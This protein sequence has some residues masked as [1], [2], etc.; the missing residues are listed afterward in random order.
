M[1]IRTLR[2]RNF[3]CYKSLE[4]SIDSMHALVGA[5]NAGKSTVLRA[6]DFLFNPSTRKIG[7]ESFYCKDTALTIEV[8]GL[9]T[10][11]NDDERNALAAYLGPDGTFR[12]VR[13]ARMST[14]DGDSG[15]DD[16]DGDERVK[17]SAYYCKPQPAIE[18]LNPAKITGDNIALWWSDRAALVHKEKSFGD[19]LGTAKPKVSD[20][21]EKA[22]EFTKNNLSQ[23]DFCDC[24]I[25]NPQGYSGVLK[26]TLPHFELIPAVRDAS[27]ESKVTRTN[28][29]G[30]LIYEI[31]RTLDERLRGELE[32]ALKATT[33]LLNR[34]G[35]E[36]RAPKVAE[37]E[38]TIQGFL[39]EVMPADLELEFQAPTV[40]VLMTTPKIHVDDGFK[41][42]IEGKGHGLQRAVIFSILRAYAKL[43]TVKPDRAKRTLILGVEEPELYMH[44]TA[45]RTIRRVL[46]AIADGGDQ[47]LFSTHSPLMVDV[48]YFDEII[49]IEGAE[50][51]AAGA[52]PGACPKRHQLT[53]QAM[54]DDLAERHPGT[55]GKATPDSI[56]E[57]YSHAYTASRNEGFFA[58]RIILVE[59]Q[60][61]VYSLPI[62]AAAMGKDLDALGVAVVEC[63]GKGQ[64]DRLYRVFNELGIVCY[65]LFDYDKGK[66]DRGV[67]RDTEALLTLLD[68]TDIK[69]PATAQVTDTFACFS[70]K[71]EA[72]L[73]SEI[74]DYGNQVKK[75]KDLFGLDD[76]GK[77]LVA[78]YVAVKQTTQNPPAIPPT[79]KSVIDKALAAKH[80]GTCLRK[81]AAAM[82]AKPAVPVS[83]Q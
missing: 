17:I 5:N 28:P 59:G 70:V 20:W 50:K 60:T 4:I 45:Q 32:S 67:R 42:S 16:G 75:A 65:P 79:I 69:D 25:P 26:A 78:R 76:T 14:E 10:D 66:E 49:R 33:T 55:T 41:G 82:E 31:M 72:D 47:V 18:W 30:R 12:V 61:E 2:I 48:A 40:E 51:P 83:A 46:R 1:K 6:M 63:G 19:M 68:R 62:Y 22:A 52:P 37:I 73:E 35:K 74:A 71:W 27:D 39:T 29:F 58:K 13:T 53:V 21:K 8:E 11:L 3:R 64:M 34:E 57:R 24:W 38:S 36:K 23:S 80:P 56:R 43:V 7:E 81:P 9:F 44:P 54:I 77:P 15:G